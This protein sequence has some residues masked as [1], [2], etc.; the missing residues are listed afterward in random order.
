MM[1]RYALA[2]ALD[3]LNAQHLHWVS[4]LKTYGAD[5][6]RTREQHAFY[7][8]RLEGL[9]QAL[10]YDRAE[11][12][13]VAGEHF[14]ILTDGNGNAL[15]D[16]EQ[17]LGFGAFPEEGEPLEDFRRDTLLGLIF[18]T[19]RD[20]HGHR[21]YLSLDTVHGEICARCE[22]DRW[23]SR[24]DFIEVGAKDFEK[25]RQLCEGQGVEIERR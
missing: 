13:E 24:S 25:L 17:P 22:W 6:P 11:V 14:A 4:M 12:C 2:E 8:G 21:K 10:R 9:R 19:R 1:N 20:K 15:P 18:A 23:A 5:D 7:S 3:Q 16:E